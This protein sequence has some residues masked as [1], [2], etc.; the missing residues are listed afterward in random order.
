M[1]KYVC[2]LLAGVLL[3]SLTACKKAEKQTDETKQ[4]DPT[5]TTTPPAETCH[6]YT[7]TP[8][9]D[10]PGVKNLTVTD[11][12]TKKRNPNHSSFRQ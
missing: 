4:T 8:A 3:L 1:K 10:D 9:A 11:T 6:T 12:V 7:L 2:I 5:Q